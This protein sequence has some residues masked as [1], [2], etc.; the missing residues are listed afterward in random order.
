MPPSAPPVYLWA[1][2]RTIELSLQSSFQLSLTVL[3]RYRTRVICSLGWSLPP[4]LVCIP[5]QTDSWV[6]PRHTFAILT[7]LTPS[8]GNEPQSR[9][10]RILEMNSKKPPQ[11]HISQWHHA[12]G[13]GYGLLPLRSPL[14]RESLLV[15]F[16][17][18]TDMLKFSGYSRLIWGQ[19]MKLPNLK[20]HFHEFSPLWSYNITGE[21]L[22]LPL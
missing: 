11:H 2:S 17:P 16:P 9:G 12:M 18:L 10:L 15:S 3:V 5:K 1:V 4:D 21:F 14:L 22:S 13:F 19:D 8:L 20:T 6:V 7:G